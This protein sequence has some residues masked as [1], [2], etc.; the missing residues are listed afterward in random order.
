MSVKHNSDLERALTLSMAAAMFVVIGFLIGGMY[1]SM[2]KSDSHRIP[3]VEAADG[4]SE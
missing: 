3:Q 2:S 4:K 1:Y